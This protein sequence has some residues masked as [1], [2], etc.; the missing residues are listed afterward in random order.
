MNWLESA[1]EHD[2]FEVFKAL[3]NSVELIEDWLTLSEVESML[4]KAAYADL[5]EKGQAW[6]DQMEKK[7]SRVAASVLNNKN[8][9]KIIELRKRWQTTENDAMTSYHTISY[10]LHLVPL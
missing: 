6:I 9:K 10:L 1:V 2:H 8:R 7:I 3:M 5:L 4:D